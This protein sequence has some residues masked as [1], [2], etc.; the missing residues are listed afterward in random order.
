MRL[1]ELLSVDRIDTALA[2]ADKPSALRAMAALLARGA[3][4]LS[5]EAITVALQ[6]REDKA[7]TGVGEGVAVPHGRIAGLEHLIAALAIAPSGVEFDSI[8]GR[9]VRIFVSVI[10]PERA[11]GEHVRA[12]AAIARLLHD[13]GA[14]ERILAASTPDDVMRVIASG[15]RA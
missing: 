13:A 4:E 3:K 5:E 14:R 11:S 1:A 12:L 7:S 9:P 6:S 15:D 2:V 10:A 8:D